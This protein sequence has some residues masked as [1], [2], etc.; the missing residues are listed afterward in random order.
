MRLSTDGRFLA[1]GS[2]DGRLVISDLSSIVAGGGGGGGVDA[3]ASAEVGAGPVTALAWG[4]AGVVA[5]GA[6]SLF[7]A[8]RAGYVRQYSILGG[9]GGG[10]GG[11]LACVFSA[12][13]GGV[14]PLALAV[15]GTFVAAAGEGGFLRAWAWP[16]AA[17]GAGGAPVALASEE[18]L[19]ECGEGGGVVG[20]AL[21]PESRLLL[22]A[23]GM[24]LRL[25][26]LE[27][28]M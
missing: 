13:T 25:W 9:G 8:S 24:S 14:P 16:E 19:H 7:V 22:T 2:E 3:L 15:H 18:G 20:L 23:G 12:P 17:D 28:A 10:G 27:A 4:S 6:P 11:G 26:G 5:A 21:H 1:S